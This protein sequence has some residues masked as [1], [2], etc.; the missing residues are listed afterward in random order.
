MIANVDWKSLTHAYGRATDVP[1]N[2]M[3]LTSSSITESES[4]FGE[5][6]SSICHQ[7]D[8]YDA[9]LASLPIVHAIL[10]NRMVFN[11][12][13][14]ISLLRACSVGIVS[15]VLY[16]SQNFLT[17]MHDYRKQIQEASPPFRE[18][19]KLAI[20]CYEGGQNCLETIASLLDDPDSTIVSQATYTLA[21][22]PPSSTV[23]LP[24]LIDRLYKESRFSTL[25]HNLL[26][27]TGWLEYQSS[28]PPSSVE[29]AN[30]LVQSDDD[31]LRACGYIYL[32]WFNIL[33]FPDIST[34]E[35]LMTREV[36]ELVPNIV[37]DGGNLGQY[38]EFRLGNL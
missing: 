18:K 19:A 9:T 32:S 16:G 15:D 1:K 7:G 36:L 24:K 26:L 30:S 14:C 10:K 5:V 23:T 21:C 28:Q 37:F 17:E 11:V 31:I 34:A 8:L 25:H 35:R 13:R 29:A 20:Q 2:L 27:S 4:A 6:F 33:G 12:S 3:R 38:L 22:F